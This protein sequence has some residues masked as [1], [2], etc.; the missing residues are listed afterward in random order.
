VR[1]LFPAISGWGDRKRG[2]PHLMRSDMNH[3]HLPSDCTSS[4]LEKVII[5]RFRDLNPQLPAT[6]R[7]FRES[8]GSS[9]VLCL[10]V[11]SCADCTDRVLEQAPH[12][13]E[14]LMSL[15]LSQSLVF[16]QGAKLLGWRDVTSSNSEY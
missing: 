16:R 4:Y 12:L 5:Q 7:I 13:G 3:P 14:S 6:C 15:G 8:W 9:T 11:A 10:D 1:S 2:F